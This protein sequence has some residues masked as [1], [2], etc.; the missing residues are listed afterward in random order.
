MIIKMIVIYLFV[1]NCEG[2]SVGILKGS[3]FIYLKYNCEGGSVGFLKRMLFVFLK[4]N[5]KE[6]V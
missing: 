1:V 5:L 3:L 6:E 2:G 4:D